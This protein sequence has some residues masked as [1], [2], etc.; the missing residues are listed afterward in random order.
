M[1]DVKPSYNQLGTSGLHR[2]GGYVFEEFLP[3]LRWPRAAKIYK[4]MADNDPTVGAIL[5]MAEMIVR[6]AGWT[7]EACSDK[8]VDKEAA[9]F[10]EE[11]MNDMDVSWADT[12]SEI[13]S[14][15]TY[16]FSFHELVYKQR[17]GQN[18]ISGR[19]RSKYDDNRIGWRRIPIRSQATLHQWVFADDG[20]VKKFVQLAYPHY[21]LVEIPL[22]KGLL[23]RTRVSRDNPES[24]SLL[25]NAYR[26][27]YYKKRIEEIEGIG[28]ERDLAGLPVLQAPSNVDLWNDEDPRMV[29]LRAQ[30]E[31]LVRGVRRDAE[32]GVLLPAEWE[33]SLLSTGSSRQFDTNAIINRYDNRIAITMLSDLVLIGGEKT[34]SFA[35][36]DTK[37]SLLSTALEAQL[38]NIADVFNN[39]AVPKLFK[40]NTF[41]GLKEY[42]RVA[43]GQLITPDFKELALLLRATG[44]DISQ[45]MELMNYIRKVSNLPQMDEKLFNEVYRVQGQKSTQEGDANVKPKDDKDTD[46]NDKR[47]SASRDFEQNDQAYTG[48]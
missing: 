27:W 32:E 39:Y 2:Y 21:S 13:L 5:Y 9:Q 24:K 26:P 16:G 28:I 22:E 46:P 40:Y 30:A 44:L 20:D 31:R 23:F 12:I 25:R 1:A 4:E 48:Q 36:A 19:Y 41:P 7:A 10:L 17:R 6:K 35:L 11:C 15:F 37:K 34:G 33:L 18:Q 8:P 29:Q 45:D 38:Q 43:P 3:D 42:P 47:D 14:M